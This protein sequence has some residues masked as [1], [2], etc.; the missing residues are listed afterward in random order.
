MSTLTRDR[1]RLGKPRLVWVGWTLWIRTY[2]EGGYDG[3]RTLTG[4]RT[5]CDNVARAWAARA[6]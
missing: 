3:Y 5:V 6:S 2:R 1:I 4:R